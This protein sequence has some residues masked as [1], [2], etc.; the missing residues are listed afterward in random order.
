ME[1]GNAIAIVLG[2][3][4]DH[5]TLIEKLKLKGYFTTLIDYNDNPPAKEFADEYIR[6]STLDKEKI[7]EIAREK[8]A[9]LV[10]ATCID[11]ALLTV[12]YVSEQ[13]GLPCHLTYEQALNLTNKAYMKKVFI[14]NGIPTSQ[15]L[16]IEDENYSLDKLPLFKFPL[17]VKPA[18]ANSSKGIKRVDTNSELAEAVAEAFTFSRSKKVVIEEFVNGLELSVDVVIKD[19]QA[20]IILVTENIKNTNNKSNF[21]IVQNTFNINVF[22]RYKSRLKKIAEDIAS[23][24]EIGN[25]PLLIQLLADDEQLSVI[26]FSSRIGGGSKHHFIYKI[27]S[28]DMLGYFVDVIAGENSEV[29]TYYPNKFASINYIYTKP[30]KISKFE[31]FDLLVEQNIIHQYFYYKTAGMLVTNHISSADRPAG[32]M[33]VDNNIGR[34]NERMDTAGKTLKV[35]SD[36]GHNMII[37]G[38]HQHLTE[39]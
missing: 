29:Q 27:S 20:D 31:G 5:I 30:G 26:E 39:F 11:Q 13:L 16:I 34:L 35:I 28:F 9:G 14:E 21:T 3:T 17:V 15:Y 19:R 7:L 22:D 25:G 1:I 24:F 4:N 37:N 8:Q 2:G 10:I 18:D 6:E 32:Y 38:L 23:A 33:V 12:A 36:Q